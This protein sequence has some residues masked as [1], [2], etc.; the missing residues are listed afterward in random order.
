MRNS[1]QKPTRARGTGSRSLQLKD[2]DEGN[3]SPP[4]APA[5]TGRSDRAC[6][7]ALP[8]PGGSLRLSPLVAVLGALAGVFAAPAIALA[9]A[10]PPPPAVAEN[11]TPPGLWV[12]FGVIVGA[13]VL[14]DLLSN[15]KA[16]KK[17]V[18][19]A[20]GWV[21]VWICLALI[22]NL[23]IWRWRGS[24]HAVDFLTGY[25]IELNLS[26]DNLFVFL[27]IFSYFGVAPEHQPR[28]LSWGIFGAI[29]LRLIF[30]F[31][32]IAL[33]KEFEILMYGF[34]AFLLFTGIK[35][36]RHD[37]E[38]MDPE[39]NVVV[40]LAR[41]YLPLA[42]DF[43]GQK[44]FVRLPAAAPR[45]ELSTEPHG[46]S[47]VQDNSPAAPPPAL[48]AAP[49]GRLVAT[50][51]F[52]VLLVIETTDVV[53]AVDSVPAIIG[54]TSD[55]FI[56]YTS[57]VFAILGLRSLFFVLTAFLDKFHYLKV[58]LSL[59]LIF[60]GVKMLIKRWWHIEGVWALAVVVGVLAASIVLSLLFPPKAAPLPPA[61]EGKD[62]EEG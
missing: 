23:A 6:G 19:E 17:G 30:I 27:V 49:S 14:A 25:L 60:I 35:L 53:F 32:G 11:T 55:S 29:A 8:S 48:T 4:V 33:V 21:A 38:Q 52:L 22:F 50:P 12:L 45:V 61:E 28:V 62:L 46:S 24:G 57:N 58:G 18:R 56:A 51:L 42:Q 59:V 10:S 2:P 3:R 43:H 7:G 34:G 31:V 41:R 9:Q 5:K 1:S 13:A 20:L 40:R 36:L 37:E 16:H 54:I 15:R 26:V 47:P 44:F 39:K